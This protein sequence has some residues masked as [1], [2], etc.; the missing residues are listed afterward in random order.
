MSLAS[1]RLFFGVGD[2]FGCFWGVT[3]D[4]I[5]RIAGIRRHSSDRPNSIGGIEHF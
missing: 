3:K 2:R 1:D 4:V 5:A